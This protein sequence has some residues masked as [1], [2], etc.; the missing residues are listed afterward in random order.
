[1][2]IST[3]AGS[4]LWRELGVA[5]GEALRGPSERETL[6]QLMKVMKVAK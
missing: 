6:N 1:M 3:K 4:I 5:R 2:S